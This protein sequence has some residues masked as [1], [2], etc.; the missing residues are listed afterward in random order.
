MDVNGQSR[1]EGKNIENVSIYPNP[2]NNEFFI[3]SSTAINT[4]IL[5]DALGK[6]VLHKKYN[7]TGINSIQIE[8]RF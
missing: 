2:F 7:N 4:A 1:V 8:N 3:K 5:T 6:L